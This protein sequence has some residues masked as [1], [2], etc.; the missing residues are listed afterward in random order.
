MG[1]RVAERN[2]VKGS[3]GKR[4]NGRGRSVG[5]G[6]LTNCRQRVFRGITLRS[7]RTG[8]GAQGGQETAVKGRTGQRRVKGGEG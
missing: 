6:K 3:R 1:I 4:E 8:H 7:L 2:Q 5:E